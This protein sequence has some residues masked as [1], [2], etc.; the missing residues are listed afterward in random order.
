MTNNGVDGQAQWWRPRKLFFL[1]KQ[2]KEEERRG[3]GYKVMGTEWFQKKTVH[4]VSR[5]KKLW[6]TNRWALQLSAEW[7]HVGAWESQCSNDVLGQ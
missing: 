6:R 5:K 7:F 4:Y 3:L 2:E 1:K